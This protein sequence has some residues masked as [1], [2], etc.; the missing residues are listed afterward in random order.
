VFDGVVI[1]A[2]GQGKP[3]G[4]CGRGEQMGMKSGA[5]PC[6]PFARAGARRSGSPTGT[7]PCPV[8]TALPPDRATTALAVA[9]NAMWCDHTAL[10]RLQARLGVDMFRRATVAQQLTSLRAEA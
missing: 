4:P 3:A 5:D 7:R 6:L 8:A 1:A 9:N 2:P 10:I